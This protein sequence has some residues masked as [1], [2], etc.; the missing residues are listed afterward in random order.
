ME[1]QKVVGISG[2][3]QSGKSSLR[4]FLMGIKL[5]DSGVLRKF[6][7]STKGELMV[8]TVIDSKDEMRGLDLNQRNYNFQIY[9][10]QVI[11]PV[12]KNYSIANNLKYTI[13]DLFQ[14][15]YEQC[16]GSDDDKNKETNIR[17]A[18]ISF[19]LPPRIV[20]KIKKEGKIDYFL[21][22]RELMETFSQ[23]CRNIKSDCWL[24]KNNMEIERDNYPM[25]IV[26]D[27]R[28]R[29]ELISMKEKFDLFSIRLERAPFYSDSEGEIDLDGYT[30]FDLII[31]AEATIQEKN[32]LALQALRDKGWW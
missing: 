19:A 6:N 5:V 15:E 13:I 2:K 20:G 29:N 8:P 11:W 32:D 18:D 4:N 17:W 27:I 22:A 7:I 14:V 28:Y 30:G 10:S 21:T 12:I 25:S 24:N 16:F 3:K 1:K 26:D 9:A 31:P 23:L